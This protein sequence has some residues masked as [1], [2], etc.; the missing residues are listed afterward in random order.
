MPAPNNNNNDNRYHVVYL[1]V[2]AIKPSPE[3]DQLYGP[4]NLYD[5]MSAALE[6]SIDE[7]GL[8]ARCALATTE[9]H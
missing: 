8:A 7:R 4:I 9:R 1:S 6:I 3:N 5:D 2:E